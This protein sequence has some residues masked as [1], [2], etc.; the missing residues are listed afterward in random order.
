MTAQKSW[1]DAEDW[2]VGPIEEY[3]L[4]ELEELEEE[5][6]RARDA[7]GLIDTAATDG[8]TTNP[9][10][11]MEQGL[12]YEPP[13]DPPVIPSDTPQGIE[14]AAGFASSMEESNPDR[15]ELPARVDNQDLDLEEDIQTALRYNSETGHLDDIEVTVRRGIVRLRGTV[16]SDDD[17]AIVEYLVRELDGVVDVRNELEVAEP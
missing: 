8:S 11:A 13:S 14:M 1:P 3:S 12:V 15:W 16:I 10:D 9:Q 4:E 7:E 6:I 17:I 5:R 2:N